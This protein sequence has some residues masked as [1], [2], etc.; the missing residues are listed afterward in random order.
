MEEAGEFVEALGN[1]ALLGV[2][3]QCPL[4][5]QLFIDLHQRTLGG[6]SARNHALFM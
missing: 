1:P 5:D 4:L 3:A 2:L 6:T